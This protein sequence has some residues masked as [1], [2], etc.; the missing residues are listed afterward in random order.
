MRVSKKIEN[1]IFGII[2]FYHLIYMTCSVFFPKLNNKLAILMLILLF[3]YYNK[4]YAL[5]NRLE[6]FLINGIFVFYCMYTVFRFSTFQLTHS[7]YY[8]FWLLVFC[9]LSYSKEQ[10]LV[11]FNGYLARKKK[12]FLYSV[13]AFFGLII[14]SILFQNGLH[15]GYGSAIPVLY[16]PYD[17][18]HVLAYACIGIYCELSLVEDRYNHKTVLF[19]K[20]IC[21]LCTVWTAARSGV[22][23]IALVLVV[24]YLKMKKRSKKVLVFIVA[25]IVGLY[26]LLFTDVLYNNPLIQKTISAAAAGS[27]TN[28]RSRFT[29]ILLNYY[30][31][32]TSIVEKTFGIGMNNVRNVMKLDSTIGVAIHAHN[33]YVN[34]LCGYGIVG[35]ILFVMLQLKP[36]KLRAP[37]IFCIMLEGL[38][39]ILSYYNGLAM[40]SVFTPVLIVVYSFFLLHKEESN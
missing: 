18:P 10:T 17:V 9:F 21:V 37:F 23:A 36:L 27:I 13:G 1:W 20:F 33:D 2:V 3:I 14:Y 16:G 7:D 34:A 26:L 39:F 8:T 40:Y 29:S 24:D 12:I 19:F 25:S 28:G 4:Q 22:L 38:L 31:N 6:F 30:S 5:K 11:K 35:M 32:Y 15:T